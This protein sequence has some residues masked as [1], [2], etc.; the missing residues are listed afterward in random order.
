M[1]YDIVFIGCGGIFFQSLTALIGLLKDKDV[2]ILCMDGDS[3]TESNHDRQWYGCP[4]S[5][6][7]D[8]AA[9]SFRRFLPSQEIGSQNLFFRTA[10]DNRLGFGNPGRSRH[11]DVI[12]V[13]CVDNHR[14][15][16][17]VAKYIHS[18]N[19]PGDSRIYWDIQAGCTTHGGQVWIGAHGATGVLHNWLALYPEVA[20]HRHE[21]PQGTVTQGVA[22][23]PAVGCGLG[24][25]MLANFNTAN[26]LVQALA[27][28]L[29]TDGEEWSYIQRDLADA[30][31]D[32]EVPPR[33][34]IPEFRWEHELNSPVRH[35]SFISIVTPQTE[36]TDY[37]NQTDTEATETTAPSTE[38][39]GEVSPES[40]ERG[41]TPS[42]EETSE[43]SESTGTGFT[44]TGTDLRGVDAPTPLNPQ[45]VPDSIYSEEH[46]SSEEVVN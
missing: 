5:S 39:S 14:T 8:L 36:W 7:A 17:E 41:G 13:T 12:L 19:S 2:R 33:G 26:C 22:P 3:V 30:F 46:A 32:S 28:V 25:N 11:G 27:W 10:E 6:K 44:A 21:S 40:A 23:R 37:D 43:T 29:G 34:R 9:Q 15:R 38:G 18:Q 4:S 1:L 42:G 24:Q 35:E 45:Q 16:Y 20:A 31:R